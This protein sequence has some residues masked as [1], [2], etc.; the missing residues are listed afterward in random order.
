MG[1]LL[2]WARSDLPT[3]QVLI[4]MALKEARLWA[5]RLVWRYEKSYALGMDE[6]LV[7]TWDKPPNWYRV[8]SIHS[9]V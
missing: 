6:I 3:R 2:D 1:P 8:C 7:Q 4:G 5:W 9:R